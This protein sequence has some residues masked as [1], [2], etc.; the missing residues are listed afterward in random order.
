MNQSEI[1][2]YHLS[3]K[4]WPQELETPHVAGHS[5]FNGPAGFGSPDDIEIFTRMQEG[6]RAGLVHEKTQWA[7]FNRGYTSETRGPNGERIA[8][9]SSE[10]EQRSIY[11][12]WR[13]LMKGQSQVTI[14]GK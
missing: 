12:A 4:G 1:Q 13:A 7:L 3:Y 11:Y 8:H 9:T 14:P 2:Q 5:S 10:V 6:Y